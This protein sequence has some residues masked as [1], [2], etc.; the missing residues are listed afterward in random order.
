M[1]LELEPTGVIET[2][3]GAPTR[4]WKG[5]SDKGVQVL[6]WM[7]VRVDIEHVP[8]ALAEDFERELR[9][10]KPERQLRSI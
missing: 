7:L 10:V 5:T 6:C 9:E 2:V 1:K 3:N 4:L 8:P